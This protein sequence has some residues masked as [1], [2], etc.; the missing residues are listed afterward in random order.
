MN[1]IFKNSKS[2]KTSGPCR[3]LLNCIDKINLQRGDKFVAL[4]NLSIYQTWKNMKKSYMSNKFKI[5]VP[6]CNE[7][8][9]LSD[10]SYSTSKIQECFEYI[11]ASMDKRLLISQ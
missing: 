9:E 11:L 8:F 7:E 4:S 10:G 1:T 3:N 2:S 6:T 5:P